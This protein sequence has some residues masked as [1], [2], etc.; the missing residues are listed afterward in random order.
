MVRKFLG[1]GLGEPGPTT[2]SRTDPSRKH[3]TFHFHLGSGVPRTLFP[4]PERTDWIGSPSG[5]VLSTCRDLPRRPLIRSEVKRPSVQVELLIR[6]QCPFD[7]RE[8]DVSDST[9]RQSPTRG[10]GSP[11]RHGRRAETSDP[12]LRV[13][14]DLLRE[15]VPSRCLTYGEKVRRKESSFQSRVD[16]N[17]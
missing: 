12:S 9:P 5:T 7:R 15:P 3:R 16:G 4:R 14:P 13:G 8:K 17:P 6:S 1:D 11:P 10:M 2:L